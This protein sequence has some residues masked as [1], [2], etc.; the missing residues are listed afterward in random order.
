MSKTSN[1]THTKVYIYKLV[2]LYLTTQS[3][4]NCFYKK[5]NNFFIKKFCFLFN[6]YIYLTHCF[7]YCFH[8][9]NFYKQLDFQK[10][11]N[12]CYS[13]IVYLLLK[14]CSTKK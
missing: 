7:T 8:S 3:W 10:K 13:K 14:I 5:N 1:T 12:A 6:K 11:Q 4:Q 9:N 2:K